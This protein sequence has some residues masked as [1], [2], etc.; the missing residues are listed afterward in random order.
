V[1]SSRAARGAWGHCSERWRRGARCGAAAAGGDVMPVQCG[2]RG[3]PWLAVGGSRWRVGRPGKEEN[4][5]GLRRTVPALIYSKKIKKA[6]IDSIKSGPSCAPKISN[7]IWNWIFW[8]KEHLFLLEIFKFWDRIWI[9]KFGKILGVEFELNLMTWLKFWRIDG[10]WSRSSCLHLDDI[11]THE[12]S[13][14]IQIC[15]LMDLPREFDLNFW[16]GLLRIGLNNRFDPGL[17]P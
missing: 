14:E 2:N 8:N 12:R 6:W 13:L 5:S 7:K 9:K 10:F 1:G 15:E 4:G 17:R 3:G 16:L 11:S